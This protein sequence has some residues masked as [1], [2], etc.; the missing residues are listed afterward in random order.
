[1]QTAIALVETG[2]LPRLRRSVLPDAAHAVRRAKPVGTRLALGTE[3]GEHLAT[4]F[5][6]DGE[7]AEDRRVTM[8]EASL[9]GAALD[10]AT[11]VCVTVAAIGARIPG[12]TEASGAPRGERY[13]GLV[14]IEMADRMPGVQGVC[15]LYRSL[16]H[17]D[18]LFE[19]DP[20]GPGEP[21]HD[22]PSD[23]SQ[24]LSAAFLPGLPGSLAALSIRT[25][26][27]L[28]AGRG[29]VVLLDPARAPRAAR[30]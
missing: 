1:M 12:E 26:T 23:I 5:V 29:H 16:A 19:R 7:T 15:W 30:R 3:E 27:S 4:V 20:A 17:R 28:L 8:L 21:L 14:S 13:R 11:L 6:R 9:L 18:V 24:A 2:A 25:Y 22:I 10:A